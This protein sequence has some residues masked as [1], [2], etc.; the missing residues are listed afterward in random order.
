M[1][2]MIGEGSIHVKP[3]VLLAKSCLHAGL[4]SDELT[5]LANT[6]VGNAARHF[7]RAVPLAVHTYKLKIPLDVGPDGSTVLVWWDVHNIYE[8]MDAVYEDSPLQFAMSFLGGSEDSLS[9]FWEAAAES[10][11]FT[12]HPTLEMPLQ[13]QA[14]TVP[15]LGFIDGCTV[16]RDKEFVFVLVSSAVSS[17]T[18]WDCEFPCVAVPH[19]YV[20]KQSTLYLLMWVL[21]D[22]LGWNVTV[23]NRGE[24]P[25]KGYYQE[26]FKKGSSQDRVKGKKLCGGRFKASYAGGTCDY[27]GRVEWNGFTRYYRCIECCD[28]C[29]GQQPFKNADKNLTCFDFRACANWTRR[30]RS[31]EQIIASEQHELP[32][33]RIPGWSPTLNH[34]D[35]FHTLELGT[36]RHATARL[37]GTVVG[38]QRCDVCLLRMKV[39]VVFVLHVYQ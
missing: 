30:L 39:A 38:L 24:G 18:D 8:Y 33:S 37:L 21:S 23:L 12:G 26:E 15:L 29:E 1:L 3:A 25:A 2:H 9:E 17:G 11:E 6:T 10:E 4:K 7:E 28:S 19:E 22:W 34:R 27:K 35:P 5:T 31:R 13:E 14:R 16:F 20:R 36:M 32:P